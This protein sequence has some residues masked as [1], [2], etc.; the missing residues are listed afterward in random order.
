[1]KIL[2]EDEH[3]IVVIKEK[4]MPSQPDLTGD[5]NIYEEVFRHV[6]SKKKNIKLGL[7]QRL[8]RPVGGIMMLT[9]SSEANKAFVQKSCL[10]KKYLAVVEGEAKKEVRLVDYL[11]KVRGNRTIVTSKQVPQ[12]KE[13]ALTYKCLKKRVVDGKTLSLLEIELETG[14]H[15][16]IRAQM[17]HH[18]LPIVGDTKYNPIKKCVWVDIGLQAYKLQIEHPMT[19]RILL[20][21]HISKD[22]PFDIFFE[23][24]DDYETL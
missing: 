8:D 11:Q 15:H 23:G 7:I 22:Y 3:I 9:K 20:F 14:R 17:A 19:G 5:T 4:G 1:M 12:A 24:E 16:Q 10:S 13:A 18:K 21:K 6:C 2:Y